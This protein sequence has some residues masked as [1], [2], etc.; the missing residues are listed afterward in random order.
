MLLAFLDEHAVWLQ[1]SFQSEICLHGKDPD[2]EAM[3]LQCC[4]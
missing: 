4:D 3:T 2:V 1:S